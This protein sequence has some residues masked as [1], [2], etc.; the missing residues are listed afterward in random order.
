MKIK[1]IRE[2]NPMLV[3]ID[4]AATACINA[5]RAF[6][7]DWKNENDITEKQFKSLHVWCD[8]CANYLNG[9]GLYRCSPVTGKK[10]PWT[11]LAFK[12]DV[13]KPVLK[14]LS[15]KK[16]TKD[17]STKDPENVRLAISGHMSTGY[18]INVCL[19]DWPSL[20]G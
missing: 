12:E 8:K 15:E 10:I 18:K 9:I 4:M 2:I 6:E 11:K 20:R 3:K 5:G 1:T 16:S 7:V 14:A 17:Q 19:P 13:Y